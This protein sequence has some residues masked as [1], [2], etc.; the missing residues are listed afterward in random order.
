MSTA[1]GRPNLRTKHES[2]ND[3]V[4]AYKRINA[5][6]VLYVPL[7]SSHPYPHNAADAPM[8]S[9][10][11]LSLGSNMIAF[12]I[13]CAHAVLTSTRLPGLRTSILMVQGL[14]QQH[15]STPYQPTKVNVT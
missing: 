3:N 9:P 10:V 1:D 6:I 7:V 13:P 8:G 5:F 12:T 4:A 11:A 14:A 15:I 2:D